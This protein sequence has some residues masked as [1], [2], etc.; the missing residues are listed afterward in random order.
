[1]CSKALWGYKIRG[2]FWFPNNSQSIR[3][4]SLSLAQYCRTHLHG[5]IEYCISVYYMYRVVAVILEESR[6]VAVI[7]EETI[8]ILYSNLTIVHTR[9]WR[10]QIKHIYY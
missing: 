2:L 6:V 10:F 1:M 9:K 5:F 4:Y 3:I 7:L 8:E